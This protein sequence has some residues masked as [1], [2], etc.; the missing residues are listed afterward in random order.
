MR[1][2]STNEQTCIEVRG[3]EGQGSS[4]GRAKR[5]EPPAEDTMKGTGIERAVS[6]VCTLAVVLLATPWTAHAS[7]PGKDEGTCNVAVLTNGKGN[8]VQSCDLRAI[9]AMAQNGLILQ[10]NQMGIVSV[11]GIEGGR[12][13]KGALKWFQDAAQR[14]YAP[15]QVNLAAM[16]SNGWGTNPNYGAALY[17]LRKAADQN[18][19]R[20]YY[21]LGLLYL[22]GSGVHQD[23]EEALRLFRKGAEGGDTWA[24]TNLGY[25]FDQGLGVTENRSEAAT[26][27]RRAAEQGSALAQNNLADLY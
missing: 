5:P 27:Y 21:D 22:Q 9:Q 23:Y 4:R 6:S 19:A 2:G 7:S 18:Y 13:A 17:W 12:D 8:A 3:L 14:G 24:E 15:A 20:A 16:Y 26:W 10:Q 11:L 25:M 1:P